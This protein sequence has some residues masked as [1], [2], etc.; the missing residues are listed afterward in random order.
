MIAQEREARIVLLE[1]ENKE[2]AEGNEAL[3]KFLYNR[4]FIMN[5]ITPDIGYAG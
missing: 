3:K 1:I 2:L 5:P 4:K